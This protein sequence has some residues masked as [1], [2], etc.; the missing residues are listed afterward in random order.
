[1]A[2]NGHSTEETRRVTLSVARKAVDTFLTKQDAPMDTNARLRSLSSAQRA[3]LER[4]F[5]GR[6]GPASDTRSPKNNVA[7]A[8]KSAA[9]K[10][11]ATRK[12]ASVGKKALVKRSH[13]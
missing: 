2:R 9:V 8:K 7:A 1:M 10:K 13:R 3:D 4:R 5:L 11:L 6:F 12:R